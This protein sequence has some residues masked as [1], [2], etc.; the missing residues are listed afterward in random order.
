[1][2]LFR[3]LATA[4]LS[5]LSP[6]DEGFSPNGLKTISRDKAGW[7]SEKSTFEA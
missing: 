5:I 2:G 1:M 3:K 6:P 4:K 7:S